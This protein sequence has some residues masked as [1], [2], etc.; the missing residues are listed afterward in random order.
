M[1]A[2]SA[3]LPV[4]AWI[5]K[6]PN[7]PPNHQI[8]NSDHQFAKSPD[9]VTFLPVQSLAVPSLGQ[10]WRSWKSA[11][12]IGLLA[13]AAFAVGIGSATAIYTV[14]NT[15]LLAPISYA[16]GERFVALYGATFSEPDQRSSSAFADLLEYQRRTTSFDVFGWFRLGA[17][18]LTSPGEAQHV[19]VVSVMP[20]L[21]HNVG[22]HPI[23]GRWFTDDS[24][25]VISHALWQR[26]GGRPEL[27]GQAITLDGRSLTITGIMPL[28]F[29]LPMPA[30]G[31]EGFATDLWIHLDPLGRGQPED[32]AFFAYARRRPGVTLAAA[33]AEVRQIAS[34]IAKQSPISHP[35]YTA[36][37]DDLLE[38]GI[39]EI[40]PTLLLLFGAAGLL[41]LITCANVAGLLLTR[42]VARARETATRVALGA[43]RHQLALHYFTEGLLVSFAGAAAGILLSYG[44]VRLV[45]ALAAAYLPR[46]DEIVID[47]RVL[48]FGLAIACLT[49]ALCSLAPLWHATRTTPSEILN[50][51]VRASASARVRRV[52][53]WLVVAEIA[54]AFAL[55]VVTAV[56]IAHMRSLVRTSPGFNPEQLLTF[57]LTMPDAIASRD[58]SRAAHQKRLVDAIE[59]VPGVNTAAFANQLPLD[60]CCLSGTL[61]PEGRAIGVGSGERVSL[62]I[63]T[64]SFVRAMQIPL[65]NG[66]LLDE[67]D[68]TEDL[69]HVAI[70][71][72]AATHYW[73]G[74]NPIDAY[75][76]LN[77]PDGPRFQVV[78]ILGDVRNSGLGQPV[79]PEV[80]LLHLITTV[81]PM[82]F[83]VRSQRPSDSV[84]PEIRR[85]VASVD[86]T[87]PLYDV[88]PM[89]AIVETW[90]ARERIAS[91]VLTFFALAALVMA[92]LGVYGVVSYGVRQRTVEIGTRLA[93]GASYAD[94]RTM[95]LSGGLKMAM[96]GIAAGIVTV[97]AGAAL[98]PRVVDTS[99]VDIASLLLPV[100]IMAGVVTLASFVPA[101]RA[102]LLS[103]MAAIRDDVTST[104]Q[105]AGR[106]LRQ[107]VRE[108]GE[109]ITST[110]DVPAIS[111]AT[112]LTE[113]V[114]AA[115]RSDSFADAIRSSLTTLTTQLRVEW[116]ALL[117]R[118]SADE[119]RSSTATQADIDCARPADGFLIGRLR[120]YDAPLALSTDDL[121][122][123]VRWARAHRPARVD[124]LE[125]LRRLGARVA[126]AVRTK[127]DILGLLLLG[128]PKGR[129]QLDDAEKRVLRACANQFALMV[130]NARLTNRIV[131]QE[132][133][134]R[135]L[136]LAAEVQKRL[137]PERPPDTAIGALAGMSLPARTVGGDY[138]DFIDVGDHRI[139]IA[140]ADVTGKGIAA[141][142]I[143][144]AVQASLRIIASDGDI[145]LTE[146]VAKLNRF[147]H[148]STASNSYATF[149][150]A[151]LDERHRQ[152]RYVNAGHNPP[153]L[154]R[155]VGEISELS[156]GGAVIGLF[157]HLSYDEATVDL[158]PGDVVVAFTDGVT[159]ALNANE[160]E[161]G[162]ERLKDLLRHVVHLSAGEISSAIAS[163]LRNWIQDAAQ[164]DDLTFLVLKVNHE[165]ARESA[166]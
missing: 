152:L 99:G 139:G 16:H 7:K 50:A 44:L 69:L 130:E 4:A 162:E 25:A 90:L 35:S 117:V 87:M 149:F 123:L 68:A 140:L 148:R 28:R 60:G 164:Y 155:S 112:L 94:I 19:R 10:A 58:E 80:Y 83:V 3:I 119:Y 51:G 37:T 59:A 24:G 98:F 128:S 14:I 95:V 22:V 55:L 30:F 23:I 53:R 6:S 82:G 39:S 46:A 131:E 31:T 26:L 81:D 138:Y 36:R 32:S 89:T 102:T 88:M 151:Q 20:S 137:L 45:I 136:A 18:N 62:V 159:E 115:R 161:F 134:R 75:G 85:A 154:V 84:V 61:L 144:S 76:R 65:L 147:L 110:A 13:V 86:P 27:V 141:A 125:M 113:F 153:Y 42:S 165:A 67:R 118:T 111:E 129:E 29:R 124:E 72:A 77:G 9:S 146:L 5:T 79:V 43:P 66:R 12:A 38:S 34:E 106:R 156:T 133:L 74:Q 78:G 17:L 132:K 142:L 11:K 109:A 8:A 105:A 135:D 104:W 41:V 64:P 96:H 97:V 48:A 70:N 107:A 57:N 101:R 63:A 40:R 2:A 150:Y 158:E 127:G 160:E 49:S 166:G 145:P 56:L 157:P 33:D 143:M 108:I 54:L 92:T 122:A 103:P 47:W 116:G 1:C 91:S 120:A 163:E 121:D 71:Q 21:A 100:V 15:V 73:P 52:S 126:V 114:A 93:L